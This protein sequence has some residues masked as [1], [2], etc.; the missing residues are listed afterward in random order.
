[1]AK[2]PTA[3]DAVGLDLSRFPVADRFGFVNY[4]RS[5]PIPDNVAQRLN[6]MHI[7]VHGHDLD[8]S[9]AYDGVESSLSGLIGMSVPLEAELPVACGP[10]T[11]FLRNLG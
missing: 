2:E 1:M 4:Q 9:G 10:L 11:G 6:D 8:G 3:A 5:F 7:V